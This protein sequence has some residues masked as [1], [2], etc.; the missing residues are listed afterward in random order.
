MKRLWDRIDL[1]ELL[2]Y[3]ELPE[4]SVR[5][6]P[7]GRTPG[8]RVLRPTPT[9]EDVALGSTHGVAWIPAILYIATVQWR[10]RG[11]SELSIVSV[12][13]SRSQRAPFQPVR[14]HT[15]PRAALPD[16]FPKLVPPCHIAPPGPGGTPSHS[17]AIHS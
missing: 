5:A 7:R 1:R 11:K 3:G 14:R 4:R 17:S 10:E 13:R 8:H 15:L 16:T 12:T 9:D 6:Q 2:D